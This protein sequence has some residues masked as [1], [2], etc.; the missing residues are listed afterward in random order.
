MLQKRMNRLY[1]LHYGKY[2]EWVYCRLKDIKDNAEVARATATGNI[3]S[4][5]EWVT[6]ENYII[7]R[8][9]QIQFQQHTDSY[10]SRVMIWD[11][12]RSNIHRCLHLV[13]NPLWK[14]H[15]P[16]QFAEPRSHH[17]ADISAADKT[18]RVAEHIL[19]P[20]WGTVRSDDHAVATVGRSRRDNTIG[21]SNDIRTGFW[22]R[23][24]TNCASLT[25]QT[26]WL[27]DSLAVFEIGVAIETFESSWISMSRTCSAGVTSSKIQGMSNCY[28]NLLLNCFGWEYTVEWRWTTKERKP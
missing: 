10:S 24:T 13:I 2:G 20:I 3:Q 27:T 15:Q 8:L 17:G 1:K 19:Q 18:R 4:P 6:D 11:G 14:S 7:L 5:I 28:W 21:S 16:V 26:A 22:S 12:E 9:L 25:H 23:S